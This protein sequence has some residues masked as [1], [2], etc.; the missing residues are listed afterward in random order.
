MKHLKKQIAAFAVLAL[1]LGVVRTL[2]IIY[3]PMERRMV[4]TLKRRAVEIPRGDGQK[5]K[6]QTPDYAAAP[7]H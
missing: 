7:V 5:T 2:A 1:V 3:S 4:A 6:S